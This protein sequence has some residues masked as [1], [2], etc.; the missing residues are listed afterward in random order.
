[1]SSR[2]AK[3]EEAFQAALQ[4]I[5]LLFDETSDP[6]AL[7]PLELPDPYGATSAGLPGSRNTALDQINDPDEPTQNTP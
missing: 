5:E 2:S 7:A 6:D 4:D 1:M 3:T